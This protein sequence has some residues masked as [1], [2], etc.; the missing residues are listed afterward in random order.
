MSK[1]TKQRSQAYR[2]KIKADPIKY[3]E[4]LKRD[5]ERYLRKKEKGVV[6]S[7]T[8]LTKRA[9]RSKRREWRTYQQNR[10]ENIK[11]TLQT[12][13]STTTPPQSLPVLPTDCQCYQPETVTFPTWDE[14]IP[15][16]STSH[17]DTVHHMQ[18]IADFNEGL[19]GQWCAVNYDGDAYPGI[20]QDVDRYGGALVKTMSRVGENR[21]FWPQRDDILWYEPINV[22]GL[23]PEPVPVT[24]R[25]KEMIAPVWKE[26]QGALCEMEP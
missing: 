10:R 2:D 3:E 22:L 15:S 11:K 1:T 14:E 6:K 8:E 12:L 19:L 7:I 18:R 16:A 20:I 21:F 24:K 25:H 17:S 4:K 9:Q 23:I 13:L 5:R 26:I